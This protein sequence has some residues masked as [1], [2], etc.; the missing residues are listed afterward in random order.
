[1]NAIGSTHWGH[2]TCYPGR[3]INYCIRAPKSCALYLHWLRSNWI[4]RLKEPNE[5]HVSAGWCQWQRDLQM[6]FEKDVWSRSNKLFSISVTSQNIIY[7]WKFFFSF[8]VT[9]IAHHLTSFTKHYALAF[10]YN[11]RKRK[12]KHFRGDSL[13]FLK[14]G[15]LLQDS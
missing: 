10:Y 12:E 15:S 8:T 1:M 4:F 6:H 9:D 13:I 5:L 2:K 3:A 7:F 14:I 11:F